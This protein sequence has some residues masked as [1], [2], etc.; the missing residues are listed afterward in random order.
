MTNLG[1][2]LRSKRPRC[3]FAW[4]LCRC[5]YFYNGTK[6]K[7]YV[8][9]KSQHETLLTCYLACY[10][11]PERPLVLSFY[12]VHADSV[13]SVS[14]WDHR[15]SFMAL[16]LFHILFDWAHTDKCILRCIFLVGF[17]LLFQGGSRLILQIKCG[18]AYFF[19][20]IH[21]DWQ[22]QMSS[23]VVWKVGCGREGK[24]TSCRR[25]ISQHI[26]NVMKNVCTFMPCLQIKQ[27][28]CNIC[29]WNPGP[30]NSVAML[31]WL[32]RTRVFTLVIGNCSRL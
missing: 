24:R 21:K 22:P 12:S 27:V 6:T 8:T 5:N 25:L 17:Y 16:E 20:V 11:I 3:L 29:K 10:W 14:A 26:M 28:K 31:H 7:S 15:I 30:M 13:S 18:K 19:F 4:P 32:H 23:R 1:H 9:Y 2:L